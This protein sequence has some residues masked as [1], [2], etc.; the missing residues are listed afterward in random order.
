[1]GVA[2][3]ESVSEAQCD[4][5]G[6]GGGFFEATTTSI[7]ILVIGWSRPVTLSLPSFRGKKHGR[8]AGF[9][10][11]TASSFALACSCFSP[12]PSS[13]SQYS[14]THLSI[15]VSSPS[16]TLASF[17]GGIERYKVDPSRRRRRSENVTDLLLRIVS[18][19]PT[20]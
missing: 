13:V 19:I 5:A 6:G 10:V 4:R 16:S 15:I 9:V 7:S 17:C 14:W 2:A 12:S 1:M 20:S 3:R 18:A 8:E 11:E